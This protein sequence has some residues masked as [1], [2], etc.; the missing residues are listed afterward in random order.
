MRARDN[1][2]ASH[3]LHAMAYRPRGATWD[4]LLARLETLGRRAAVVGPEGSGKTTF[5]EQL[6]PRLRERGF[7]AHLLR[8][9]P[10]HPPLA[11]D[12]L[13]AL[14]AGLGAGDFVLLDGAERLGVL[15]WRR[16]E[17]ATRGAGGLVL[18]AHAPGRLPTLLE[19]ATDPGLLWE[20]VEELTGWPPARRAECDALFALHRGDLRKVFRALY[21]RCAQ[22]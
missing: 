16:F 17:R 15:A 13:A 7:S 11:A 9:G 12:G 20:L 21:D 1:P 18:A 5:L 19:T 4:A 8:V 2:F 22:A 6:A 3:R 14:A 10:D